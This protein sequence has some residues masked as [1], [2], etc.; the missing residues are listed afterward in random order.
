[1]DASNKATA[2]VHV[3]ALTGVCLGRVQAPLQSRSRSRPVTVRQSTPPA[4]ANGRGSTGLLRD[5]TGATARAA[6][7]VPR[8][9]ETSLD[10]QSASISS[11]TDLVTMPHHGAHGART[12]GEATAQ[13]APSSTADGPRLVG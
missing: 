8:R 3:I 4:S 11:W 6:A 2:A 13:P 1:M 7:T 12:G 5:H 10:L 9:L